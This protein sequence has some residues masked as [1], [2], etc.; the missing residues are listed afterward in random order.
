MSNAIWAKCQGLSKG[1]PSVSG[2]FFGG[3]LMAGHSLS[4]K[5]FGM[6][7][8][9][10]GTKSRPDSLS[11]LSEG[12]VLVKVRFEPGA[13]TPIMELTSAP[14]S[15]KVIKPVRPDEFADAEPSAP[16]RLPAASSSLREPSLPGE[17]PP[18][19][20]VHRGP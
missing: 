12:G 17:W 10:P 15:R 7:H 20:H 9:Q 5:T 6:I 18:P 16:W 3:H 11:S 2:K 4:I 8:S 19:I 14:G 13:V 1:S